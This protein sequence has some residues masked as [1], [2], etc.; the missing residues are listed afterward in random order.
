MASLRIKR[1]F[2]DTN[3]IIDYFVRQDSNEYAEKLLFLGKK[4][5]ISFYISFLTVANFAYIM[6]KMPKQNLLSLIERICDSFNV[7]SNTK[8]QI[9]RTILLTAPDFED[10]LQ[11]ETALDG[12][13]DCII[14]RNQ[15]DFTFSKIPVLSAVDFLQKYDLSII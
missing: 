15:K 7:I 2:L 1:L 10:A 12:N 13:C 8:V 9:N 11:Y 14:T 6:R 3:F 5:G 4:K